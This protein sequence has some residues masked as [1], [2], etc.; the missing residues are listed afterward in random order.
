MPNTR[1]YTWA[2][3]PSSKWIRKWEASGGAACGVLLTVTD[4]EVHKSLLHKRADFTKNEGMEQKKLRHF[5]RVRQIQDEMIR[6]AEE[7]DWILVEQKVDPDP[8]DIIAMALW[9]K[10]QQQN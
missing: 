8:L 2:N 1:L 4:E 6:L 5:D 7:S 10:G 3:Q 9:K